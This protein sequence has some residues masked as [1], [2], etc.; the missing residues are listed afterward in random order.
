MDQE[1]LDRFEGED[2]SSASQ[3]ITVF[4]DN[5]ELR[6]GVS[7]YLRELDVN[8]VQKQLSVGD[9]V[10]SDRVAI[11]RKNVNEFA[12]SIY[13]NRLFDE[14]ARLKEAYEIPILVV[15]GHLSAVFRFTRVNEAS[16]WGALT[17]IAV[18]LKVPIV[19]TADAK[20]TARFVERVAYKEQVKAK[21]PIA[22]R[23]REKTLTLA[24]QQLYLVCGLPKIGITLAENLLSKA[25]TPLDVFKQIAEAEVM[26]SKTGK[27][28]RLS[29]AIAD[30]KGIGPL[31]VEKSKRILTT[32][33]VA[34]ED[35]KGD[36]RE[37][38]Q[39]SADCDSAT[40]ES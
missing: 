26:P 13:T 30:V 3:K 31:I 29:G 18:E 36:S 24:Q 32:P 9:Y 5:R 25:S 37:E 12:N 17:S 8:V 19:P 16:V 34:K 14:C 2:S 27:T 15:E 23:P 20:Q 39:I 10:V 28:R 22:I 21:R 4:V 11:E 38:S 35:S 1:T 40:D 33:Y 6:S 7:E